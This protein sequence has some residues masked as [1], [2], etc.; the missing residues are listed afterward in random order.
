MKESKILKIEDVLP[1]ISDEIKIE[2]FKTQISKSINE[3]E[4]NINHLKKECLATMR[5]SEKV[6][7]EILKEGEKILNSL[8]KK[9]FFIK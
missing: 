9:I 3:Y 2:D 4:E 7:N 6:Q 1:Y 8:E 5:A